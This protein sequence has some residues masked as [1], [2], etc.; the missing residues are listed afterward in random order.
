LQEEKMPDVRVQAAITNWAP[1][2]IAQ[3]VDYNDFVRTTSTIERW[4]EWL[5]AWV[6]TGDMH[7]ELASE[8][9]SRED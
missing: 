1:R 7:L 8:A 4:D 3:G 9:E 5:D 6:K 2:F